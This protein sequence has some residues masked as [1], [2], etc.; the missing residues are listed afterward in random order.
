MAERHRGQRLAFTPE[1]RQG[2]PAEHGEDRSATE[3]DQRQPQGEGPDRQAAAVEMLGEGVAGSRQGQR[4]HDAAGQVGRDARGELEAKQRDAERHGDFEHPAGDA[5]GDV[6]RH[7]HF[8]GDESPTRL[9]QHAAEHGRAGLAENHSA[10]ADERI[11]RGGE[12]GAERAQVQTA[13]GEQR[14]EPGEQ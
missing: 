13:F 10:I 11:A 1:Q 4:Q 2:Q 6:A 14:P 5:V 12:A 3:E 9:R 7:F 8:R